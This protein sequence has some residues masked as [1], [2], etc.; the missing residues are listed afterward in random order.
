[1]SLLS[2]CFLACCRSSRPASALATAASTSTGVVASEGD[3]RPVQ[4]A[5]DDERILAELEDGAERHGADLGH[6]QD[7]VGFGRAGEA[8]QQDLVGERRVV[9]D[10]DR[11]LGRFPQVILEAVLPVDLG[12]EVAE[13]LG[14]LLRDQ[15]RH[16]VRVAHQRQHGEAEV[17]RQIGPGADDAGKIG[18]GGLILNKPVCKP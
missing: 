5:F 4:H 17:F 15:P 3:G 10:D 7:D 8:P 14:A 12:G 6:H 9:D 11:V 1:M 2:S 16:C 13:M 18:V